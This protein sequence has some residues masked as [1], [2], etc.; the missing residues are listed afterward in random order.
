MEC[1]L[2]NDQLKK[3]QAAAESKTM[4]LEGSSEKT[5]V[6]LKILRQKLQAMPKRFTKSLQTLQDEVE[7]L[8]T[9]K[10]SL[11]LAEQKRTWEVFIV[12]CNVR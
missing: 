7:N 10:L 12:A 6:Q 2:L 4:S 8:R 1:D 5:K 11:Q 9:E 3:G